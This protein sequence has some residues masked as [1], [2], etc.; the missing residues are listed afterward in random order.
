M[1]MAISTI[2]W[3]QGVGVFDD[4]GTVI[5][6]STFSANTAGG[7]TRGG[8]EA[9]DGGCVSARQLENRFDGICEEVPAHW[10]GRNI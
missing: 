7:F 5:Q 9:L 2:S 3:R 4:A 8:Q 1:Q 10:D 6:L